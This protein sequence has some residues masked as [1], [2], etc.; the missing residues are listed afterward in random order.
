[1]KPSERIKALYLGSPSE[2]IQK[3]D[4]II[5]IV[6]EYL[7]YLCE[8]AEKPKYVCPNCHKIV[9]EQDLVYAYRVANTNYGVSYTDGCKYC[10]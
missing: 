6:A 4:V 2:L 3:L 9:D 5:D 10:S 1:M 7:D 8:E